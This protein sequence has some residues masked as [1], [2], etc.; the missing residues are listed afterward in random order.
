MAS[1]LRLQMTNS[2][3]DRTLIDAF[4]LAHSDKEQE[5]WHVGDIMFLDR[6]YNL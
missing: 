3:F 2:G 4:T 6:R 1:R 5:R